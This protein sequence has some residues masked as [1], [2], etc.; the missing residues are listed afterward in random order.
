[1]SMIL[2]KA[3]SFLDMWTR[4]LNAGLQVIRFGGKGFYLLSHLAGSVYTILLISSENYECNLD[5][6]QSFKHFRNKQDTILHLIVF[7]S[8]KRLGLSFRCHIHKS[9]EN[10]SDRLGER[11]PHPKIKPQ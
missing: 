1:M 2:F 11:N 4:R 3:G 5:A 9:Y 7:L 8:V 10:N 6:C